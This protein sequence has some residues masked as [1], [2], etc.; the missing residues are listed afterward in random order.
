LTIN[1]L[2]DTAN[3]ILLAKH[4]GVVDLTSLSSPNDIFD[5]PGDAENAPRVGQSGGSN[6]MTIILNATVRESWTINGPG[7]ST[8][9]MSAIGS[10]LFGRFTYAKE[11]RKTGKMRE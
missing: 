10:P 6:G 7:Q 3:Y 2:C 11:I 1:S 4:K 5:D 9:R 8:P